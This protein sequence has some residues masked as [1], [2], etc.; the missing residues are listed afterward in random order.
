LGYAVLVTSV[1]LLSACGTSDSST[2]PEKPVRTSSG[3]STGGGGSSSGSTNRPDNQAPTVPGALAAAGLTQVTVDLS[4]GASS[5]NVAVTGYEVYEGDSL[6]VRVATTTA[7]VDQL[8]EGT[9]Y[10]FKVRAVDAA[11]NASAFTAALSVSTLASA[12]DTQGATLFVQR[13]CTTCH[14]LDGNG[15]DAATSLKGPATIEGLAA[16]IAATM[17]PSSPGTCSG[18]CATA[19]ATYIYNSFSDKTAPVAT[20]TNPLA[21]LPTGSA[22]IDALCA[23]MA[24]ANQVNRVRDVFCAANRPAITSLT[25]LQT[26]LGLGF[27]ANPA[28]GRG[29]NGDPGNGPAF[30]LTG[31]SS[32][33]VARSVSAINPRAILFTPPTGANINGYITMGFVRGD[34]LVELIAED[35]N[36]QNTLTFFLVKFTQACNA[37]DSCTPGDLFTPATESNWTSFTI[38]GE[39][40]LKN[41]IFDCT[42]CHQTGGPGTQRILRMQ[43]LANPWNHWFRD[44]RVGGTALLADYQAAH[45][46]AETYAGIPGNMISSSDP[47]L[48][49]NLIRQNGFGNQ[50]NQFNSGNIETQ[51]NA[52]NGQPQNNDIPGTSTVWNTIFNNAVAGRFIPVPYHDIK[53]TESSLLN[54]STLAYQNFRAGRLPAAQLPDLTEVFKTSRLFEIAGIAAPPNQTGQQIVTTMCTQCHNTQLDQ[55]ISRARFNVDLNAMSNLAGGV[56]AGAARDAEIG[57]AVTRLRLPA[58]D[59]RKMPPELLKTLSPAEVDLV[60][61]Y[62]CAQTSTPI[63]QCATQ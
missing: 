11:G 4:W 42:H 57:V 54:S 7:R 59:V 30:T 56:L 29:N 45:G 16:S 32:S 41:T 18:T 25:Q 46:T 61:T 19:V 34:Q 40:D 13:G 24:A 43:E 15:I 27:P 39:D 6:A 33:L 58:D 53:I 17:P 1:S 10:Q 37:T 28:P 48:L 49:E 5:D 9:N 23:R 63:P 44:N 60:V 2:D 36:L 20:V 55:T 50:P 26:A 8:T 52:T 51:V 21:G 47:A 35:R 3:G 12:S 31:H 38:Y 14:G 22:Q 62:L